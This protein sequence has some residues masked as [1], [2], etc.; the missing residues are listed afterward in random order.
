MSVLL[1]RIKWR[2]KNKLLYYIVQ[3]IVFPLALLYE[4]I[5]LV[6]PVLATQIYLFVYLGISFFLPLILYFIDY[7]LT[8]TVLRSETWIYIIATTGAITATLLHKQITYLTFK[9]I[10]FTSRKS[11]RKKR[12]K[13]CKLCEY[14]VSKSNI[15]LI[16]YSIFFITLIIFNILGLQERSYYVNSNIDIA[17]LQSF[18]TFVAFE[19]ILDDLKLTEF[20]PS[21]LIKILN[22]SVFKRN[23]KNK[24]V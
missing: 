11:W 18:A 19:R 14:I 2:I 20:R 8:L 6:L 24:K 12:E 10:P 9:I 4:F 7:S 15:K 5:I 21:E 23:V 1:Y 3:V 13:L 17:I 22:L 16:I